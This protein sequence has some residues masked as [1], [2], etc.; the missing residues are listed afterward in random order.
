M[1]SSFTIIFLLLA[2]GIMYPRLVILLVFEKKE[3]LV[4]M[5]RLQVWTHCQICLAFFLASLVT[6]T[7][8]A[9]LAGSL[10]SGIAFLTFVSST[11][12]GIL[13][14]YIHAVRPAP[15][16]I[17]IHP[18]LGLQNLFRKSDDE[19]EQ[20]KFMVGD[21]NEKKQADSA[22]MHEESE[23]GKWVAAGMK[24]DP[25]N[26]ITLVNLRRAFGKKVA[27]D[28]ISLRIRYGETFGL[29][30]PNG[31]GKTTTLSML[32]GLLQKS[33][34]KIFIDGKSIDDDIEKGNRGLRTLIGVT[35]QFDTV[36]PDLTV[37]EHLVF[38]CRI[39]A[40]SP[41]QLRSRVRKIAEA[42]ELDGDSFKTKSSALSG[43]MRRRLSIGISMAADP[44]ILV[45]D[46]PTTGLDPE[47]R[48]LVWRVIEKLRQSTDKDRCVII[49]THSME[50]ADVL[51]SRI[52]IVC[53]GNLRVLGTQLSLKNT[54]GNE[55]KL[56]L[57]FKASV[58]RRYT[59]G[60]SP[61]RAEFEEAE[62]KRIKE[63]SHSIK[64]ILASASPLKAEDFAETTVA[65]DLLS[66]F[67]NANVDHYMVLPEASK[68]KSYSW[69]VTLQIVLPK[70]AV[71]V[72]EIFSDLEATCKRL[73]VDDWAMSETTLEDVFMRVTGAWDNSTQN[74][75][76]L[77]SARKRPSVDDWDINEATLEDILM[78]PKDH[79]KQVLASST[80]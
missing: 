25:S 33:D 27:V 14:C 71:N 62:S 49:T 24:H 72:A 47:T 15:V 41:S 55:F 57:R 78:R 63:I 16:G 80:L 75:S 19:L 76:D 5:M 53:Q 3:N 31:A 9:G 7:V 35:P 43:G 45:L 79:N 73:S 37:E 69:M 36:W 28:Q 48:R 64:L 11:L 50:E 67:S 8:F 34:G 22:V 18:L 58:T 32:T 29:L 61:G 44:K 66:A 2:S 40:L 39:H 38:Y 13:G 26:A 56:T 23:V 46:E 51:S 1:E 21:G 65:S 70:N 20:Q 6:K 74:V 59:Q 12:I 10:A 54:F 77:K 52:G 60:V 30:G 4:E 42:I 68:E 17:A